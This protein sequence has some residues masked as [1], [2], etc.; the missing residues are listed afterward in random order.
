LARKFTKILGA[1]LLMLSSVCAL[2]DAT[3]APAPD[4]I[5]QAQALAAWDRFRQAPEQQL[6]EAPTFLKFMQR[7]TQ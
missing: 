1:S 6:H 4:V 2:A 5:T 7:G 3:S